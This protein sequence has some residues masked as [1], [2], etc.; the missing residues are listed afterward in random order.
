MKMMLYICP[1]A[2]NIPISWAR[3]GIPN[4]WTIYHGEKYDTQ[5]VFELVRVFRQGFDDVLCITPRKKLFLVGR[6]LF[7]F[8]TKARRAV[9]PKTG[10]EL[11]PLTLDEARAWTQYARSFQR[12]ILYKER[13]GMEKIIDA[14]ECNTK[15]AQHVATQTSQVF[16]LECGR[17]IE[18]LYRTKDRYFVHFKYPL[19]FALQ[20][21]K[22]E[23][24][25]LLDLADLI[26]WFESYSGDDKA[27]LVERLFN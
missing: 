14:I 16:D 26:E 11:Q 20:I 23:D 2:I 24:I 7:N 19:E 17:V 25:E 10:V 1:A 18:N 27:S 13:S 4:M 3:R 12:K 5:T 8:K 6:Y 21:G 15:K 9:D 22:K